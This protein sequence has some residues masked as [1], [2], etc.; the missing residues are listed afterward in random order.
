[1]FINVDSLGSMHFFACI[2]FKDA[3]LY[4]YCTGG[5]EC[6]SRILG[7]HSVGGCLAIMAQWQ[8]TGCANQWCPG[9][10]GLFTFLYFHLI[11]S[12][13]IYILWILGAHVDGTVFRI[14]M[15]L[16]PTSLRNYLNENGALEDM[17]LKC[18]L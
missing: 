16:M 4:M 15:E 18:R 1:M 14:I 2:H 13:F 5:T 6:L 12:K 7:S 8:S 11:A 10:V 3:I 17:Q 9:F